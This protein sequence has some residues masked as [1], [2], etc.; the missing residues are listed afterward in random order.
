MM[1][2]RIAHEKRA[3]A[4]LLDR[5]PSIDDL[6]TLARKRMPR[7]A[8]E[9]LD[10][11]TGE[12]IAL[13]LN[14]AAFNRVRI[15][16][17]F[18]NGKATPNIATCVFG[19]NFDAPFGI[20]PVGITGLLWPGGEHILAQTAARNRIPYCLSVV[21][22]E[23]P[24]SVG[25]MTEG[26]GWFQLYPPEDRAIR[27]DLIRRARESGF[28][29][30]I[31][32]VDVPVYGM[33]ERQRRVGLKE[34]P[35]IGLRAMWQMAA[36]PSWVGATVRHG[37]PRFRTLEPY[38]RNKDRSNASHFVL[39]ELSAE[40]DIRYLAEIREQWNGPLLLKGIL[41]PADARKA[42]KLGVDGIIVS[43]H[44]GRQFDGAPASIQALPRIFEAVGG[45]TTIMLDSGVRTGLDVVRAIVLGADFVLVGRGFLY[46]IGALG[47][48][49][50]DHVVR[51]LKDDVANNMTQLG[52]ASLEALRHMR[53]D[54]SGRGECGDAAGAA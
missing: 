21:A 25:P 18:L 13:A 17:Q 41:H 32:T 43:N 28:K 8:W 7:F 42:V 54:V 12:E 20:A 23:T 48:R 6:R 3:V 46:G 47:G 19:Q 24:E 37:A 34:S 2:R 39:H 10:A 27:D 30:L 14:R 35:K 29:A 51:I 4:D 5:F 26:L 9:H 22:C 44:G 16:P 45:A 31:V 52:V 50:G 49:G 1:P 40:V 11:G 33:R 53:V 38:A 15:V 36:R